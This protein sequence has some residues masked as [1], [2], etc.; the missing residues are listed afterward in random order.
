MSGF[1]LIE[2]LAVTGIIAL[3]SGLVLVNNNRFGGQVLL[4]NL[5]YDIALSVRQ[6]Q[7]SGISVQ[8]FNSSFGSAYGMHFTPTVGDGQS[9][10]AQFADAYTTNGVL[11]ITASTPAVEL[12]RSTTVAQGYNISSVCAIASGGGTCTA[13]SSLDITF[14]RP[15]PDACIAL[16][17]IASTDGAG[18]CGGAYESAQITVTSPRSDV[19]TIVIDSNGQISVQ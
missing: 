3:I 1:T 12:I 10:Y 8:Q 4:E 9:V 11:D 17:G 7:I 14:K 19:R 6:A 2:L 5:A 16:N 15:E 18:T 13:G